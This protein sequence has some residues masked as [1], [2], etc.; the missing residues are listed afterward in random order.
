MFLCLY[1][2][3]III[4]HIQ[5][6]GVTASIWIHLSISR[7]GGPNSLCLPHKTWNSFWQQCLW[8][9]KA[10]QQTKLTGFA[11]GRP[12]RDHILTTA[13]VFYTFY[14]ILL[15]VRW[16]EVAVDLYIRHFIVRTVH[17]HQ[18]NWKKMGKTGSKYSIR[19]KPACQVQW[20][21]T[22]LAE[23]TRGLSELLQ[24]MKYSTYQ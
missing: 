5:I 20:R 8:L 17:R 2:V 12:V 23:E 14:V 6:E 19:P 3:Q 16:K 18:V 10:L 24:A 7:A 22:A 1:T 13:L 11:G 15:T 4:K 21:L 9:G